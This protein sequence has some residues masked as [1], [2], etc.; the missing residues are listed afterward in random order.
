VSRLNRRA[1][2]RGG[3]VAIG[4]AAAL[5]AAEDVRRELEPDRLPING[6]YAPTED[7]NNLITRGQV[8]ST[9]FVQTSE[10]VVALTFDDGPLPDWTP[11]V[12]DQLDEV[13]A[14]ATFFMVGQHL[15]ANAHLV[16]HRMDRHEIGNHTWTH[17][18]LAEQDVD[19]A[20]VQLTRTADEI[21]TVFGRAATIM[22]PPW[23]HLA[24]STVLA[25]SKLDYDIIVWSQQMHPDTYVNDTAGQVADIVQRSRSGDIILAHDVGDPRRLA[26]LRGISD[27]VRGL[28]TKGLEPVTVSHL[29]SVATAASRV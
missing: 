24:G 20:L 13:S 17:A 5:V 15:R 25:A 1:I 16:A 2:L 14:S 26:G 3:L 8:T 22:R 6:G 11:L 21:R 12:L 19:H 18:D 10:P 4:G 9:F 7:H 28:R 29:L 23:G 27:I